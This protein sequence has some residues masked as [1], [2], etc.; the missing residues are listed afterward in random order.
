MTKVGGSNDEM[1]V[2]MAKVGGGGGGSNGEG[3]G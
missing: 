3:G 2:A 1:G